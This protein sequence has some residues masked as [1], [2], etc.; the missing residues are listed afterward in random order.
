MSKLSSKSVPRLIWRGAVS[1][2]CGTIAMDTLLYKRYRKGGGHE[3][4]RPWEFA[5][6]VTNWDNALTPGKLG[7]KLLRVVG[8]RPAPDSWAR[9][10]TNIVHWL[11]GAGWGIQYSVLGRNAGRG[12]WA[13]GLLLGPSAWAT[14]YVVLPPLGL[15]KPIWEY[16]AGTLEKDLSAHMLFGIVTAGALEALT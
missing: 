1:G 2:I 7:G 9:P 12:R 14:S 11:T 5:R 15:Y 4:I 16:D 6:S 3:D 8:R 10:T 13:L